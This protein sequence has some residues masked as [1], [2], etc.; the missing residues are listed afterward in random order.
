MRAIP[1][2]SFQRS[3]QVSL[4]RVHTM[5]MSGLSRVRTELFQLLVIPSLAPHPVQ[6][7]RESPRHGYLGDLSSPPQR[8]V[9][10]FTAPF[11][12][13]AHRDLGR[14]HQQEA[15]QRVTLFRDVS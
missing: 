7:N 11:L 3:I 2:R 14:F 12:V 13:A 9:E 8:Q 15:Q 1:A 6:T 5:A 10:K 4:R